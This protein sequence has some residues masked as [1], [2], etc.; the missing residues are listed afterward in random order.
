MDRH[1]LK[2]FS[3]QWFEYYNQYFCKALNNKY[4]GSLLRDLLD[5]DTNNPICKL[6]PNGF[7]YYNL[8]GSITFNCYSQL[9]TIEKLIENFDKVFKLMHTWDMVIANKISKKINFGFDTLTAYY[10]GG[11]NN[12]SFTYYQSGSGS[13]FSTIRGAT[14]SPLGNGES[15]NQAARYV[16][17]FATSTSGQY[18]YVCHEFFAYITSSLGSSA[19][20]SAATLSHTTAGTSGQNGITSVDFGV[21]KATNNYPT[22]NEDWT[23]IC[24]TYYNNLSYYNVGEQTLTFNL[25]AAGI[26]NISK[27]GST[28][29]KLGTGNLIKN[30]APTWAASVNGFTQFYIITPTTAYK[31]TLTITYT[32]P[33]NTSQK[34]SL[35]L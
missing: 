5:I 31:A 18:Y 17:Y 9:H 23:E 1:S 21:Y 35:Y 22:W 19:T 25:N 20:I 30:T 16:G 27:T 29:F 28:Y 6:V 32:V 11:A 13:T 4:I 15:P 34:H 26:A 8:D 33:A 24:T 14:S 3:E 10:D 7:H 2:V 12:G